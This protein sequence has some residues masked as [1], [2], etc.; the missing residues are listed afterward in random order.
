MNDM[1]REFD[2]AVNRTGTGNMK[3]IL[4]QACPD[5]S[6]FLFGA[7]MDYPTAPCIRRALADFALNGNY[8]FTNAD[9][10][11]RNRICWWMDNMRDS[12]IRPEWIVPS[13]GTVYALCTALR[14]FTDE[15]DGVIIQSP[16]YFR[17][18]SSIERNGRVCVYNRLKENAGIYSIDM[19]DLEM[20]MSDPRNTMMVLVNPHNP[21][22]KV[23]DRDDLRE[24]GGLAAIYNVLVF[25]DE[26]FAE[27]ARPGHYVTPYW[28]VEPASITCTSLGKSFSLTGVNQA[29]V[30]IPDEDIRDMYIRQ[31]DR[32]HFGSIDP[33]FYN[34]L[35]AA[36]TKE[37]AY[38]IREMNEYN[39][40]NYVL[41]KERI[42]SRMP[43]I[44]LSPLE[45]TYVI[46]MDFRRLGLTDDELAGFMEG[47][48]IYADPG[49]EYGESGSGFF[50][51]NLATPRSRIISALDR[52]EEA[53]N[54]EEYHGQT[55][56]IA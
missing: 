7:E 18:D 26:I 51:W 5:S 25:S 48:G 29:N 54:R 14:A 40:N 12:E 34:A 10:R 41:I 22:G 4:E 8:G 53:Y 24:I 6:I 1:N 27:T 37:G 45:G 31:R 39:L 9:E 21:T 38:W 42:R 23:F 47:A 33:F 35:T 2:L 3:G 49:I 56:S 52:L 43:L 44:G 50:R 19:K 46:W 13:L 16:S 17:F 11:Y 32:D 28:S 30:I 15:G 20:K 55:E 36:Y